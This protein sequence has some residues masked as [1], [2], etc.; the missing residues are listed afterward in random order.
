MRRQSSFK[1][2]IDRVEGD[3]A[4]VVLY[5]DDAVKFNLPAQLLPEGVKGGDHFKVTFAVDK[6][7][8]DA[9]KKKV[10]DLLS[11]LTGKKEEGK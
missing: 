8:R 10:D 7:S 6:E 4:V 3:K 9:E 2:V 5:D 1:V 11:E